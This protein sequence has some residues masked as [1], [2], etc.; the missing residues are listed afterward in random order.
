MANLLSGAQEEDRLMPK[1][2]KKVLKVDS[3]LKLFNLSINHKA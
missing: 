2:R 1:E 3:S